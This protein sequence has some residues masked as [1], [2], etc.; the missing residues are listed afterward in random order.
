M[1]YICY[2]CAQEEC[3][4]VYTLFHSITKIEQTS[5]L[6]LPSSLLGGRIRYE[7][8]LGAED[9]RQRRQVQC[10]LGSKG[11]GFRLRVYPVSSYNVM[12][13]L[14]V[15]NLVLRTALKLTLPIC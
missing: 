6:G 8:R 1:L 12:L 13:L 15:Q 5:H 2:F 4:G 10:R 3:F 9:V 14:S 7:R 11:S